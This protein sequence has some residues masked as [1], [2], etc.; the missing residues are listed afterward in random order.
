MKRAILHQ[1]GAE[2]EKLFLPGL[3]VPRILE[4]LN[5]AAG[6]EIGSGKLFSPESSA[7]LAANVFGFFMEEAAEMPELPSRLGPLGWPPTSVRIE[8]SLRFPW[9]GGTHP[10]L[11]V[12]IETGTTLLG[13][14]SKRYEPYRDKSDA[15]FSKAYGRTVWG[16]AMGRWSAMRESLASG[17]IAFRHLNAAQLVKHAYGLRTEV[18]R[19]G[20]SRGKNP[21]LLYLYAEPDAWPGGR[22]IPVEA[23][24]HHRAEITMFATAVAGDEVRFSASTYRELLGAWLA[25]GSASV[26]R[27]IGRILSAFNV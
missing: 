22:A 4:S 5:A 2:L 7:M 27:H 26:A 21:V 3:P 8:A 24:I 9:T 23:R 20:S 10:C 15:G 13:I 14:E 1:D 19:E 6:N 25:S 12:L 16:D 17:E 11:D 18:H